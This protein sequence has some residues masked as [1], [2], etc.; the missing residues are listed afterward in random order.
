MFYFTSAKLTSNYVLTVRRLKDNFYSW[1][2]PEGLSQLLHLLSVQEEE[3]GAVEEIAGVEAALHAVEM[4]FW[5]LDQ[6][7]IFFFSYVPTAQSSSA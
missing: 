7:Y 6:N 5:H 2:L 4:N 1:F 3:F